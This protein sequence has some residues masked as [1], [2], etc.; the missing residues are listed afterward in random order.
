[1]G[2]WG[3]KAVSAGT[4]VT[5]ASPKD[6]ILSSQYPMFKQHSDTT[7]TV[8]FSTGDQAKYGTINHNLG[9]VP[10]YLTY[11]VNPIE[12][13]TFLIPSI[14]YGTSGYDYDECQCGTANLVIGIHL[15]S[16]LGQQRFTADQI[17]HELD[18]GSVNVLAGNASGSGYSSAVRFPSVSIAKNETINSAYISWIHQ[19]S[20][21][22]NPSDTSI[23]TFGIDEDNVGDVNT[24]KPVTT[25]VTVQNQAK[26]GSWF[27]FDTNVKS[28]VEEITT[29]S[30]WSSGNNMGFIIYDYSSPSDTYIAGDNSSYAILTVISGTSTQAVRYRGI[31]FKDKI[32]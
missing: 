2:D 16:P 31:I 18:T 22:T 32:I 9:Y 21:G 4:S 19:I 8:T 10:A 5:T 26:I 14:P 29:R 15:N 20:A 27:S 7:G 30:G 23:R 25:A 17:F 13:A 3:I 1:M 6:V 12:G 24:S 11:E 28:Q